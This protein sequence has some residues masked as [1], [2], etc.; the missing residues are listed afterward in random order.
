MRKEV[1]L[2]STNFN[3]KHTPSA[4]LRTGHPH[5]NNLIFYKIIYVQSILCND[6]KLKPQCTTPPQCVL[7]SKTE[8]PLSV[9][10]AEK[11]NQHIIFLHRLIEFRLLCKSKIL[12]NIYY[13]TI[14]WNTDTTLQWRYYKQF[15]WSFSASLSSYHS[16]V[17]L[18]QQQFNL[19]K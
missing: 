14:S 11:S 10:G 13:H 16:W 2:L 7:F 6:V 12:Q 19:K 8:Q 4:T 5:L 18:Q 1:N 17:I 15:D 9:L 3:A